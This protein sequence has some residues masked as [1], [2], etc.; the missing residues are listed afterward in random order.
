MQYSYKHILLFTILFTA[1]SCKKSF[2]EIKPK[3]KIIAT[4]TSDYDLLLNNQ[5]LFSINTN[6]Q[7][8]LG[9]EVAGVDPFL[10]GAGFREKQLFSWNYN[11]YNTD[12]DAVETLVPSK[13]IYIYNKVINE[14]M[15]S[16]EGSEVNKKSLRAEAYAGRAWTYFLLINYYGK[17][18]NPATAASDP[19]Y[20]LITEADVN[21]GDYRRASV[22]QIYDL[23]VSDLTTAIPDLVQVGVNARIRMSKAAAQGLLAKVYIFMGKHQEALPLLDESISNLS[24][25]GVSTVLIDFNTA[26]PGAPTLVNDLENVYGKLFSNSYTNPTNNLLWLTP[27][28]AAL[29]TP[30]DVRRMRWYGTRTFTNGL[31][32]IRRNT[33]YSSFYGVRVPELYLLRAEVKARLDDLSGAV[34]ELEY[35][36]K[37]RMPAADA[38][39]PAAAAAEK[40]PLLQFIMEERIREFAMQGYRWFDMRR[41]SVDPLFTTPVYKHVAYAESGDVRETYTLSNPDQYVFRIPP[42]ILAENPNMDNNP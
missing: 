38:G 1:I 35:F 14:V 27:E 29:Y 42:K 4:K 15:E 11:L 6:G 7:I 34:G 30:T 31:Q 24:Q 28:A 37:R 40:L 22:Q 8:F 25:S 32:L 5:D 23:I 13:S 20:P 17:P 19:G 21:I 33:S 9:D 41:L 16:T 36:R 26:F 10:S 12:E 18:Y 3:G 39:V 2:L